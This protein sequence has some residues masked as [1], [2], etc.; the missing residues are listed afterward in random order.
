[1]KQE[2]KIYSDSREILKIRIDEFL[3]LKNG[4]YEM[5]DF[6]YDSIC[7][8]WDIT[9]YNGVLTLEVTNGVN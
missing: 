7:E 9:I 6:L 1:M 5:T 2:I 8:I 3:N 4:I